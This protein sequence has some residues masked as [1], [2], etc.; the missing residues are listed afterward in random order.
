MCNPVDTVEYD[1]A[2]ARAATY[3]PTSAPLRFYRLRGSSGSHRGHGRGASH[4]HQ[5]NSLAMKIVVLK[6]QSTTASQLAHTTEE[7]GIMKKEKMQMK[8]YKH[9]TGA[10][11]W[12]CNQSRREASQTVACTQF[13]KS[14]KKAM[15]RYSSCD[16]RSWTC[17]RPCCLPSRWAECSTGSA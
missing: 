14:V 15:R 3:S 6:I 13:A 10:A 8:D 5:A 11:T 16:S 12:I 9:L 7:R 4:V 1:V 2:L 17:L